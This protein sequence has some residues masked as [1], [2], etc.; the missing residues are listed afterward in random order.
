MREVK[1]EYKLKNSLIRTHIFRKNISKKYSL[2][3]EKLYSKRRVII[4]FCRMFL[5][6]FRK[7][8]KRDKS[9]AGSSGFEFNSPASST[10]VTAAASPS[11]KKTVGTLV[12]DV[13]QDAFYSQLRGSVGYE[14]QQSQPDN[15]CCGYPLGQHVEHVVAADEQV[16]ANKTSNHR[17]GIN[18]LSKNKDQNNNN[19]NNNSPREEEKSNNYRRLISLSGYLNHH[20]Q[21]RRTKKSNGSTSNE[22]NESDGSSHICLN[23]VAEGKN[24]VITSSSPAISNNDTSHHHH[25]HKN[26]DNCE[27]KRNYPVDSFT[28]FTTSPTS[29]SSFSC[30]S[31]SHWTPTPTPLPIVKQP[32]SIQ[33]TDMSLSSS[34]SASN[35]AAANRGAPFDAATS[36]PQKSAAVNGNNNN[37]NNGDSLKPQAQSH[38]LSYLDDINLK[39]AVI[40]FNDLNKIIKLQNCIDLQEWIAFKTKMYFD[41]INVLYGAIA[42]HC[43]PQTCPTMSGPCN[44]Q[45]NWLDEKGK[46]YKYSASQYID[47][48][49]TYASKLLSDETQFPTKM[50]HQFPA[51]FDALVKRIHKHL[52][53]IMAHMYHAHYKELV[54]LK[55]NTY[56]NSIYF[57]FYL[58]NRTYAGVLL[59]E[60][61]LD[62]MDGLNKALMRKYL[63]ST[64]QHHLLIAAAGVNQPTIHQPATTSSSSSSGGGFSFFK[65]KLNFNIMA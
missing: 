14:R 34:N 63:E 60:K 59:E 45:F 11:E 35:I 30:S 51:N 27:T 40:D 29:S 61:D 28:S 7:T 10:T 55:L 42:D 4:H 3:R 13:N 64:G 25:H 62:V 2:T 21:H 33:L 36:S 65:K 26:I 19:L 20:H 44:S 38:S 12:D 22:S 52:F 9:S 46:K 18:L 5:L 1:K 47:T 23:S 39:L 53:Q 15:R 49:L 31:S 43:T 16:R 8:R 6:T 54:H 17:F 50:G 57:H 56:L 32:V 58:F 41:Q 37:N 48:C 24:D